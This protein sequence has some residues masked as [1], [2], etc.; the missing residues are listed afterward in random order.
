MKYY[1]FYDSFAGFYDDMTRFEQRVQ[2]ESDFFN[3]IFSKYYF[4][5]AL[6][7]GCGT[8]AHTFILSG[9]GI[10]ALGIDPSTGMIEK[11]NKHNIHTSNVEFLNIT[12]EDYALIA[13]SVF[14]SA[15][16]MGNTI[17]HITDKNGLNNFISA[18]KTIL[19]PGAI[20]IFQILNYERIL[21]EKER[22]VNIREIDDKIFI[23]FYDFH[24]SNKLDFNILTLSGEKDNRQH[25]IISTS[26]YAYTYDML[27]ELF[28]SHGF[29]CLE[30]LGDM[31]MSAYNALTSQNLIMILKNKKQK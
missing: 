7:I 30:V 29:E 23:R 31:K 26:L 27:K 14:E 17:S 4:R 15:F 11:A 22:I 20:F 9:L 24:P 10:K 8:G 6:D 2:N 12:L 1:E 3:R 13:D 21:K 25:N 16:C 19:K 28:L 18:L 5:N